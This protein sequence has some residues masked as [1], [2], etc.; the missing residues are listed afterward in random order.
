MVNKKKFLSTLLLPTLGRGDGALT[1]TSPTSESSASQ[2]TTRHSEGLHVQLF[3][4]CPGC[5]PAGEKK[6]VQCHLGPSEGS[7]EKKT[8]PGFQVWW[9]VVKEA[10]GFVVV[11]VTQGFVLVD[12]LAVLSLPWI[13]LVSSCKSHHKHFHG[14]AFF[15]LRSGPNWLTPSQTYLSFPL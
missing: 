8:S 2:E 7:T 15:C 4:L 13:R 3:L 1:S 5:S 12:S 6:N 11:F 10:F 9:D 14:T